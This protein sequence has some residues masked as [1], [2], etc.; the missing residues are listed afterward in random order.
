MPRTRPRGPA[1]TSLV[2]EPVDEFQTLDDYTLPDLQQ[3]APPAAMQQRQAAEA[4][5]APAAEMDLVPLDYTTL[6]EAEPVPANTSN[7]SAGGSA[8]KTVVLVATAAAIGWF[9]GRTKGAAAGLLI[10]GAGFNLYRASK[11]WASGDAVEREEAGRSA[12][13]GLAGLGIGGWL[14]YLSSQEKRKDA[15]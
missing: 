6:G 4:L 12:T 3:P 8:G 1:S 14:V 10:A 15:A 5:A 13:L 11:W 7:G 9:F 2:L